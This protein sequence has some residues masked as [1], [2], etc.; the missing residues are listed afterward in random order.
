MSHIA[1]FAR[2][3]CSTTQLNIEWHAHQ[4]SFGKTLVHK[5]NKD[6]L[7]YVALKTEQRGGK[8]ERRGK[9]IF[10]S[11]FSMSHVS[12]S[13]KNILNWSWNYVLIPTILMECDSFV[14]PRLTLIFVRQ[15]ETTENMW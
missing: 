15:V 9:D 6:D 2:T 14:H 5:D 10:V 7:V 11:F 8:V 12:T 4:S 3:S 13:M 1:G